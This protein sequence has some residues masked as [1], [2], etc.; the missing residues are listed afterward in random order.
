MSFVKRHGR[1]VV[2][3]CC[4]GALGFAAAQF[5]R[6]TIPNPPVTAD[7]AAPPEVKQI[8]RAACYD[9]HSNKTRLAWFDQVVPAYWL[10]ADDV[11]Q[12]RAHL[13]FSEIGRQPAAQQ[14]GAL[15][16]A[17]NQI[18]LGAMP[19]ASYR[20]LHRDAVLAPEQI[21]I[22]MTWLNASDTPK[23]TSA[24][25][26]A[27]DRAQFDAWIHDQGPVHGP[28]P[29]PNGIH[30]LPDYK[31]WKTINATDRF[32]N[33]TVRVILGN[34]EAIQ[35]VAGNHT[36][37]WPDGAAFAKVAWFA[38]DDG[39]GSVLPGAFFQVEFMIRD[40]QKYA[41]TKGWGWAR[42]RG[43]E[44]TPYGKNER[45]SSECIGC[46][47]PLR[48]TD[49]VYTVPLPI[50]GPAAL[51]GGLPMN[52]LHWRVITPVIDKRT[53][54]IGILYGNDIAVQHARS[55][56]N[57]DY[58]V[59]SIVCLVTWEEQDDDHW[60]GAKIPARPKS[61]E[62]ATV[63]AGSGNGK[64]IVFESYSGSPLSK[65]PAPDQG[66]A[67]YLLSLRAAVMP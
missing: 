20:A 1:L 26:V 11:K 19:P 48:A 40:N 67:A 31:D 55:N 22:L 63:T 47:L 41:Q 21:R 16:E 43:R 14:K 61:V 53:S 2:A 6:P 51:S 5:F 29:A 38:R 15:Y 27:A 3:V 58:P 25:D 17:V 13:N 24:S 9:C 35:A 50:N 39:N 30:F 8:L 59:G 12:G 28:V 34:A 56:S 32:D 33:Q 10:V 52:P 66:R 57:L 18:R 7:L 23:P 4:V 65:I 64:T 60:F 54:T 45:F 46:H 36:N 37:P 49:Y 42:W 44:L 62:Y